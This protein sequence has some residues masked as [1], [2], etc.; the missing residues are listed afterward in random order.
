MDADPKRQD[1]MHLRSFIIFIRKHDEDGTMIGMPIAL[2]Q[3]VTHNPRF[4]GAGNEA[5]MK[6]ENIVYLDKVACI[7]SAN[8]AL[9]RM[10]PESERNEDEAG[11]ALLMG[12]FLEMYKHWK[13]GKPGIKPPSE[14]VYVAAD[15]CVLMR[16][17]LQKQQRCEWPYEAES[18]FQ[19]M[20]AYMFLFKHMYVPQN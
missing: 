2:F 8:Q 12:A 15:A 16:N 3:V 6:Q 1:C 7:A 11:A 13:C 5:N 17:R 10:K 19:M 14:R 18:L 20:T 9:L 4:F